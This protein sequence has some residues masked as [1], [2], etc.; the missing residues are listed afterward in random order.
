[1][2][3]IH[4]S[5]F[6]LVAIIA[7]LGFSGCSSMLETVMQTQS[8]APKEE[9]EETQEKKTED[10]TQQVSG[11]TGSNEIIG[12]WVNPDYDGEG[13]SGKLVYT[14]QADGTILYKAYDNSDGSGNVYSGEVVYQKIW[15]DTEG[16]RMGNSKVTL[17]GGM[18]WETL[19]RISAD[20]STLEVQSGVDKIDPNG[21]RY[22]I[23]YRQ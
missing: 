13:R 23:Y 8:P 6:A 20:G 9:S 10:A 16:R 18:S 1:M 17:E 5:F 7:V 14:E 22:S 19:D 4:L 2:K 15:S 12:V 3:K 11:E 21:P